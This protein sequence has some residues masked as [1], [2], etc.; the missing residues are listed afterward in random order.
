MDSEIT[1]PCVLHAGGS[2]RHHREVLKPK[3]K[4]GTVVESARCSF[5]AEC[6]WI[7]GKASPGDGNV[8][9]DCVER[10]C[11]CRRRLLS[12]SAVGSTFA[13]ESDLPCATA[14]QA[15]R[16]LIERCMTGMKIEGR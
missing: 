14:D 5:N 9:L 15:E 3:G 12:G 6:I 10:R 8:E 16:L 13:F 2:R 7:Q 1:A 4:V 11:T